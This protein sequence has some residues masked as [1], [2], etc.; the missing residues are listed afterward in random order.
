MQLQPRKANSHEIWTSIS[1]FGDNRWKTKLNSNHEE[2]SSH[3]IEMKRTKNKETIENMQISR[4]N[5]RRVFFFRLSMA[6]I[7]ELAQS[8]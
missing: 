8:K 2:K 4:W 7:Y 3:S 5:Q 6:I 1:S